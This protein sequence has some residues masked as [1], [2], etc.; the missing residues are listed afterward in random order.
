[1]VVL[2]ANGEENS[3][4]TLT[5]GM[6]ASIARVATSV[7][8]CGPRLGDARAGGSAEVLGLQ[9][10]SVAGGLVVVGVTAVVAATAS[11]FRAYDARHAQG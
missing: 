2:A 10:A 1:M 8:A 4:S 3:R 5:T 11:R 9:G 6:P 7:R